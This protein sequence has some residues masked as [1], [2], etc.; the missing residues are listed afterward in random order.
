M[1]RIVL[2]GT[3]NL[4]SHLFE[5]F[6]A[7][8]AASV[9]QIFGRNKENLALFGEKVEITSDAAKLQQA[10]I[11]ICAVS[12]DAIE[13]VAR[14]PQQQDS[15][16]VH[17]SGAVPITALPK[18]RK[19]GV[20]YPLQSFS[21]GRKV[22]FSRIPICVEAESKEV[23]EVLLS[24]GKG[25]SDDCVLIDSDQRK[26]LHLAAV[27]VNNFT[28]HLFYR[29]SAICTK[30]KLPF[31][32]LQPL[33][34]ETVSK[35]GTLSPF[36]AQTGPARRG[37]LSTQQ[38]HLKLMTDIRDQEIYRIISKAIQETYGNEL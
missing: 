12:D 35:L 10:D 9:V 24:L 19:R 27:F 22:D 14:Y 29:A 8:E 20:F 17:C 6:T 26:T 32:L 2:L 11:Y 13:T 15:I 33:I 21:R 16:I 34:E 38:K 18:N 3:G 1:L 4:A 28:N 30:N 31:R 36:E 37:D 7:S 23:Q 5:A 25:I